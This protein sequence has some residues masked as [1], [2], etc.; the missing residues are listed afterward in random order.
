MPLAFTDDQLTA[1]MRLARPLQPQARDT[2][3]QLLAQEL[4]GR[5][6][7]GDGELFRVARELIRSNRLFDAPE[8]AERVGRISKYR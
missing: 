6:D 1:I 8:L 4:N 2:F 3:L 5:R 7:V